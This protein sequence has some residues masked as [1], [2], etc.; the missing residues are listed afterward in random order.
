[1]TVQK[2]GLWISRMLLAIYALQEKKDLAER[3]LKAWNMWVRGEDADGE[4]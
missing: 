4:E 3:A 2:D 1:M